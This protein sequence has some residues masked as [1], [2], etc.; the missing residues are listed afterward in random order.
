[1]D[2]YVLT[3][4]GDEL[5]L[6]QAA[7]AGAYHFGRVTGEYEGYAKKIFEKASAAT[8]EDL[9]LDSAAAHMERIRRERLKKK[10]VEIPTPVYIRPNGEYFR[11]QEGTFALERNF[12]YDLVASRWNGRTWEMLGVLYLD[13]D[14]TM[15]D[16]LAV[17]E[18]ATKEVQSEPEAGKT[19]D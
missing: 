1:M 19:P 17:L 11:H 14:D 7:V 6:V 13:G 5:A 16:I 18:T 9:L 3:L 4:T 2:E 8:G 12:A 15:E 10:K